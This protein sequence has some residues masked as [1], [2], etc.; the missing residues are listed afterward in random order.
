MDVAM[1]NRVVA[2]NN[3]GRFIREC[4]QAAEATVR[5]LV[6]DGAEMSRDLAP[7]GHKVDLRT[8]PLKQS[9]TS[10]MVSRTS[11]YWQA[12][13]RHALPIEFGAGPHEITGQV[14]FYWEYAGRWWKPGDNMIQHPGNAAQPYLRPAYEAMAARAMAVAQ[15]KYPG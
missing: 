11:G 9:I 3:L 15:E 5:E 10:K 7:T 14:H 12:S 1:S 6:E 4:E 2:R 13:A 8:I